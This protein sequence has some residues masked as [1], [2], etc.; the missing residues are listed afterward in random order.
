MAKRKRKVEWYNDIPLLKMRLRAFNAQGK[1]YGKPAIPFEML[2]RWL[3]YISARPERC[4]WCRTKLDRK[5]SFDH[6]VAL[7][8]GGEHSLGNMQF[9]C[10]LC[11]A[12]KEG[13]S[14]AQWA[15]IT[16]LSIWPSRFRQLYKVRWA[17]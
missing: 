8:L 16:K 9:V 3:K 4:P 5:V 2:H 1:R 7:S 12:Y 11:N 6:G 17:R 13:L 10:R 15:E 14:L